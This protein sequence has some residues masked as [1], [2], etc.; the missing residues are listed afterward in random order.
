[1]LRKVFARKILRPFGCLTEGHIENEIRAVRKLCSPGLHTNVVSVVSSGR[2]SNSIYYFLDMERLDF[3]LET[4]IS[5]NWTPESSSVEIVPLMPAIRERS[6]RVVGEVV[7][8]I[9]KGLAFIHSHKEIHCDLK[10][11]NG[12]FH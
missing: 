2:L 10:P 12:N 5:D 9:A 8:D 4:Y 1:M 3:N 11:R 7:K 6:W